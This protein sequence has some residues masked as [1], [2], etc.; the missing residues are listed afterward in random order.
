MPFQIILFTYIGICSRH[1]LKSEFYFGTG[2]DR[3]VYTF[4]NKIQI[5]NRGVG[6]LFLHQGRLNGIQWACLCR[7]GVDADGAVA[8]QT[9]IQA[10]RATA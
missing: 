2:I 5:S 8:K 9:H 10:A 3:I 4:Q 6:I 1:D 7:Y